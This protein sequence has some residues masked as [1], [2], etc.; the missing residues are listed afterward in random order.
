MAWGWEKSAH[1]A[2]VRLGKWISI[3]FLGPENKRKNNKKQARWRLWLRLR[4]RE[5]GTSMRDCVEEAGAAGNLQLWLEAP[6]LAAACGQALGGWPWGRNR[7]GS[8]LC[9]GAKTSFAKRRLQESRSWGKPARGR[10]G[11]AGLAHLCPAAPGPA[12]REGTG[13]A[14][15]GKATIPS[16]A[17]PPCACFPAILPRQRALGAAQ[18]SRA[19]SKARQGQGQG[20][21]PWKRHEGVGRTLEQGLPAGGEAALRQAASLQLRTVCPFP[22]WERQRGLSQIPP[23]CLVPRRGVKSRVFPGITTLL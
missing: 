18:A 19:E 15:L 22:S 12:D 10:A 17:V 3:C 1:R 6:L 16:P 9:P 5:T 14:P 21:R 4:I 7:A 8:A 20:P 13:R 2:C 11:S 23:P